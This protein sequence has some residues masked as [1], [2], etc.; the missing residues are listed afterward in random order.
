MILTGVVGHGNKDRWVQIVPD[1]LTALPMRFVC[2]CML[3]LS[4]SHPILFLREQLFSMAACCMVEGCGG[5]FHLILRAPRLA[6]CHAYSINH[7]TVL[8]R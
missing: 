1:G 5:G 7:I 6:D 8:L 2:G 4:P 3:E